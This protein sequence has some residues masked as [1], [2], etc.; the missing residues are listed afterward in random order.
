MDLDVQFSRQIPNREITR[1]D[2][3]ELA[4]KYDGEYPVETIE[5]VCDFLRMGEELLEIIDA[6][7]NPRVWTKSGST[8]VN[9][10]HE[11]LF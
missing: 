2:A 10:V 4:R 11:A 7:R 6:H 3:L 5:V 8:W 9:K 1:N